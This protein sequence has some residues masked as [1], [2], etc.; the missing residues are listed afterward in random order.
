MVH[1][2]D[3]NENLKDI[4]TLYILFNIVCHISCI[5]S[6]STKSIPYWIHKDIK[7]NRLN[8]YFCMPDSA[9]EE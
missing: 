2:I 7:Q 5:L 3:L 6:K 4:I 8:K 1:S 9:N